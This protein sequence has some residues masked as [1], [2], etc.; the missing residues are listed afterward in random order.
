MSSTA[1]S[2]APRFSRLRQSSSVSFH[3]FSG[4]FSR[5]L[6]RLSCSSGEMCS[7]NLMMIMP[8]RASIFSNSTISS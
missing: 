2:Y 4:S 3:C 8:S 1:R 6:N 5:A 7:Q